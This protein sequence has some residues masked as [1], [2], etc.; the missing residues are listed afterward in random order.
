VNRLKDFIVGCYENAER[1]VGQNLDDA[2]CAF[3]WSLIVQHPTVQVGLKPSGVTSE[4]WVAPQ[5]SAKRKGKAEGE[6]E[7]SANVSPSKL[8]PIPNAKGRP[9]ADLAQQYGDD[10]RIAIEPQA[11]HA[12]ITGTHIR[13]SL[14]K[15]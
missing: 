3:V 8:M 6:G 1:P 15:D 7:E 11:T 2:F 14:T 4:V 12:A 13:V 5:A 9:L 10:L